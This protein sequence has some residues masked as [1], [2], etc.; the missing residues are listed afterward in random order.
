M[1]KVV[2]FFLLLISTISVANGQ[3]NVSGPTGTTAAEQ[4][5][6]AASTA[7]G[8]S[9]PASNATHGATSVASTAAIVSHALLLNTHGCTSIASAAAIAS[10]GGVT[11]ATAAR[12][13]L[14][15]PS[16]EEAQAMSANNSLTL[17]FSEADDPVNATCETLLTTPLPTLAWDPATLAVTLTTN[18]LTDQWLSPS[19]GLGM[20]SFR[21]GI[22]NVTRRIWKIAGADVR[23]TGELWLLANDGTL[24]FVASTSGTLLTIDAGETIISNTFTVPADI[25]IAVTT[26][27]LERQYAALVG[28]GGA[29][30]IT[31]FYGGTKQAYLTI[32][33]ASQYYALLGGSTTQNFAMATGTIG[34]IG[35]WTMLD[36]SLVASTPVGAG[37]TLPFDTTTYSAIPAEWSGAT[38][39]ASVSGDYVVAYRL[40]L[41]PSD[42][43][44]EFSSAAIH[45]NGAIWKGCRSAVTSGAGQYVG[46]EISFAIHLSAGDTISAYSYSNVAGRR[47]QEGSGNTWMSIHR[48]H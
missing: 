27:L 48:V 19:G 1:R 14:G 16:I 34:N 22:V 8:S 23:V 21:A 43:A 10:L 39:T 30:G 2:V 36:V 3:I 15:V 5:A 42:G 38:F 11:N 37:I 26:R 28:S 32:P 7:F 44:G 18:I 41:Q 12:T 4:A 31:N 9:H 17:Y 13:V 6:I 20:T 25:T 29:S 46:Q 40:F 35:G 33:R 24:T 47:A 45:K